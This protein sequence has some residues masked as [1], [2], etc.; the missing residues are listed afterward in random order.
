MKKNALTLSQIVSQDEKK[1][2]KKTK[3]KEK[4]KETKKKKDELV[5]YVWNKVDISQAGR[6]LNLFKVTVKICYVSQSHPVNTTKLLTLQTLERPFSC[7]LGR[8]GQ[9][10]F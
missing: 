8:E 9:E 3:E 7:T 5:E 10:V 6:W 1:K 4:E 2:K